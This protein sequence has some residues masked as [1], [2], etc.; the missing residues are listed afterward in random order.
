MSE[1]EK[2]ELEVIKQLI[3][4][5]NSDDSKIVLKAIKKAKDKGTKDI[6]PALLTTY[7]AGNEKIKAE[8]KALLGELKVTNTL[9]ILITSLHSADNEISELILSSI[10][11][12]NLDAADYIPE[13]VE[14]ACTK[15]YMAAFEALTIL[16]NLEGPF[17]EEKISEAK[18]LLN[19]YFSKDPG[20]TDELLKTILEIINRMD[21]SING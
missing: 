3:S 11:N 5:L 14:A 19:E 17:E 9:P 2:R 6:I 16:E 15:G 18:L 13:I 4:E 21:N 7:S 8:I 20:E 1:T 12:S 10:W